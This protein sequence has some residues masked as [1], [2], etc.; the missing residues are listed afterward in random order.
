M[1]IGINL[2]YCDIQDKKFFSEIF[3]RYLK[4]TPISYTKGF[5]GSKWEPKRFKSA[6][7]NII[8]GEMLS[9]VDKKG[10]SFYSSVPFM[11]KHNQ[12]F[13]LVQEQEVFAP[14]EDD[15]LEMARMGDGFVSGYIFNDD[16]V[17]VHSN[18]SDSVF[19]NRGI[20]NHIIDSIRNTPYKTGIFGGRDYDIKFNPGRKVLS[21]NSWIMAAYKMWFAPPFFSIISKE[22]LI[23]FKHAIEVK[24]LPNG[25]IYVH[26]F[27]RLENSHTPDSMFRQW[28]WQE[29]IDFDAVENS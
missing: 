11:A 17:Y 13:N 27:D 3:D 14:S 25:I 23:S 6:L 19:L 24:E 18:S 7:E 26:L 21:R 2:N 15:I 5:V 12:Y 1:K 20:P 22:K 29:L 16:Y 28:K 9:I 8:P 10:N 4:F